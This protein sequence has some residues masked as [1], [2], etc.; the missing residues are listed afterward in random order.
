MLHWGNEQKKCTAAEAVALGLGS[1]Q[2]FGNWGSVMVNE[3]VI[4]ALEKMRANAA[5]AKQS[6]ADANARLAMAENEGDLHND[7]LKWCRDEGWLVL[8]G[9]MAHRTKR[10]P[11]EPDFVILMDG[12]R[13][14]L[15]EAKTRT[16][17]L[18]AAQEKVIQWAG[19]LGHT[20]HVVRSLT[21]FIQLSRDSRH[22]NAPP[23]VGGQPSNK[24]EVL[25]S[26]R[27]RKPGPRIKPHASRA[28]S[29]GLE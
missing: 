20:I 17:I 1:N 12:G 21:E 23:L 8:H 24:E 10:T 3:A 25:S 14:L 22:D 6:T 28:A 11:G 16:G 5:A 15:V 4:I 26:Q 18:S 29:A 19:W 2:V 27:L 9:S 7:I 13:V